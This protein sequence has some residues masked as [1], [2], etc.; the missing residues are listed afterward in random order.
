MKKTINVKGKEIVI[1]SQNAEEYIS[2]TDIARYK[3]PNEPKDVVKNWLRSKSTI[4]F[5]GLWE[6]INNPNF[7]GVE[8]DSFLKQAGSNTF[9]LSPQKWIEKTDAAGLISRSGHSGGTF[10]HKDIAFE[11][12]SWVSAEFKLYLI[13][14]FQRLKLEENEKLQLGWDV[15][16]ELVKINYKIHTDAIKENLI[17][18]EISERDAKMIYASEADILN[19]AL[20]GITAKEW[21]E[22]NKDKEGNMRDYANVIQLVVLANL[23]S[24]NSE[25][26][27][28]ELSQEERL[29]SL[30]RIAI[31][32]MKSLIENKRVKQL[33]DKSI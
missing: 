7:K 23:E 25:F 24:L 29:V 16:R 22:K 31:S 12:A 18:P 8:F 10:A 26:I 5:L 2:L 1:F 32:Q 11:F 17:P 30:N 15:K 19:K 3:N 6:E 13:K 28:Q 4:E 14:E 27:K 20:F 33:G 9:V 21:K